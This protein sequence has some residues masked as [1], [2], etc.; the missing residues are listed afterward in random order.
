MSTVSFK[1]LGR[2]LEL[3]NG[4]RVEFVHPVSEVVEVSGTLVLTLNV[5]AKAV[6]PRNVFGVS[7]A[8]RILWQIADLR[9][10][11]DE[12]P[13]VGLVALPDS[14][15]ANRWDDFHVWLEP[16]SGNV[17]KHEWSKS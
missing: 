4:V 12:S 10:N 1:V 14:V 11:K 2:S 15:L 8:G 13:Y 6:Y 17:L 7:A 5:L 16:Q 9:P 3:D